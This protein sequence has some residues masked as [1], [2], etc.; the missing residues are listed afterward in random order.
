[1]RER[2][3]YTEGRE[4]CVGTKREV[5]KK[6]CCSVPSRWYHSGDTTSN[7]EREREREKE[8]DCAKKERERESVRLQKEGRHVCGPKER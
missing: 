8:R 5:I 2:E 1:M 4:T 7:R 3:I 6:A